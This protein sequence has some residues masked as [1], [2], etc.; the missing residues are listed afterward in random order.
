MRNQDIMLPTK[1]T[2]ANISS[3]NTVPN[4]APGGASDAAVKKE[5]KTRSKRTR[6]TE[7]GTRDQ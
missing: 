2:A 7:N 1:S 3:F 4:P 5:R 6:R